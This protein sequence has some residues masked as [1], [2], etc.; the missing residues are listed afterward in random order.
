MRKKLAFGK[1][2]Q[3]IIGPQFPR[4][5]MPQRI[6][7]LRS[8][9]LTGNDIVYLD[10]L[11]NQVYLGTDDEGNSSEPFK[12]NPKKWHISGSLVAAAKPRIR[13]VLDRLSAIRE[14][15]GTAKVICGLP[16]PRYVD[17]RCCSA[18][19]HIDNHSEEEIS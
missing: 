8:F 6:C 15:C 10:L 16:I 14:A 1:L 13:K 17:Q 11:S 18:E 12:D 4:F 7:E 3:I 5:R 9:E 2:C 19:N